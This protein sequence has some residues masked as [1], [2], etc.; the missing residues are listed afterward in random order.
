MRYKNV[1]IVFT[2]GAV[3]ITGA[4]LAT[5]RGLLGGGPPPRLFVLAICWA[6]AGLA[7]RAAWRKSAQLR[8][9]RGLRMIPVARLRA[10]LAKISG[11]ICCDGP[12]L[13]GPLTRQPCVYCRVDARVE[14]FGPDVPTSMIRSVGPP[15]YICDGTVRVSLDPAK[16]DLELSS[17][18]RQ[19]HHSSQA[20]I[21]RLRNTLENEYK[22]NRIPDVLSE[23]AL[24]LGQ[25]VLVVGTFECDGSGFRLVPGGILNLVTERTDAELDTSWTGLVTLYLTAAVCL[26][27]LGLTALTGSV[28][29]FSTFV[30]VCPVLVVAFLGMKLGSRP[31]Q[32]IPC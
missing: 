20:D 25:T 19:I 23:S 11:A 31:I 22:F 7:I 13:V 30:V 27:G 6:F 9:L 5:H 10:G 15:C 29:F 4:V 12:T 32:M 1:A 8:L 16:V 14:P 24:K 18:E 26:F 28:V 21:D 3:L 17:V 2:A